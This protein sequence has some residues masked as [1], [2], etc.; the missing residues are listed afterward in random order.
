MV[1]WQTRSRLRSRRVTGVTAFGRSSLPLP[2]YWAALDSSFLA[3]SPGPSGPGICSYSRLPG[4]EYSWKFA[5][6]GSNVTHLGDAP[7]TGKCCAVRKADIPYHRQRL[8][9]SFW[10]WALRSVGSHYCNRLPQ[11]G[12]PVLVK[13]PTRGEGRIRTPDANMRLA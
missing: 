1:T 7:S 12:W 5:N 8:T 6:K 13:L 10:R 11:N 3:C 4:K 9:T 2:F